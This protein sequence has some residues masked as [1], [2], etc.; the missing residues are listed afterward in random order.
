V[1]AAS[2]APVA[3]L[4]APIAGPCNSSGIAKLALRGRKAAVCAEDE[5]CIALIPRQREV[6]R[7]SELSRK[8]GDGRD[9]SAL[10]IG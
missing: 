8:E 1:K 9:T 6:C 4:A 10:L 7:L 2:A 5:C 3:R